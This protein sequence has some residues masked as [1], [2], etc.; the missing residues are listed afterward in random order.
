MKTQLHIAR[1]TQ[2]LCTLDPL[3]NLNKQPTCLPRNNSRTFEIH[4][5]NQ[6]FWHTP[7]NLIED[8]FYSTLIRG[9]NLWFQANK[10]FGSQVRTEQR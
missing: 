7:R 1:R 2:K 10:L 8:F 9:G 5:T 3:C 6:N 4:H